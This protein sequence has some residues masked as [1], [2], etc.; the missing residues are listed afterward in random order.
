M[1][2]QGFITVGKKSS[3]AKKQM[4]NTPIKHHSGK[5]VPV[6]NWCKTPGHVKSACEKLQ[7]KIRRD[8]EKQKR[9]EEKVASMTCNWCKEKGHGWDFCEKRKDAFKKKEERRIKMDKNFPATLVVSTATSSQPVKSGWASVAK[10]NRD[11]K[12]VEKMTK[13]D[14]NIKKEFL[15]KKKEKEAKAHA[16]YLER[17]RLREERKKTLEIEYIADM[18]TRFGTKWFNWVDRIEG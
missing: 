17:T 18:K 11:E 13:I 3:T 15:E 4:T 14:E 5:N 9:K 2:S 1:D 6:C 10:Q 7:E 8:E 12:L 16:D